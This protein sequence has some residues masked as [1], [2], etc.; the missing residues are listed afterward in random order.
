MKFEELANAWYIEKLPYVRVATEKNYKGIKNTLVKHFGEMETADISVERIQDF[1]NMAREKNTKET[2]VSRKKI[3][4]QIFSY[5]E[6]IG[7]VEHNPVSEIKIPKCK[8]SKEI[9]IVTLGELEKLMALNI[10]QY[11]KDMIQIGFRT[12]MRI[13]EIL[14]LRWEDINFEEGYLIVNR[15]LSVY[16]GGKPYINAPKTQTSYRAIDLDS[17]LMAVLR[18]RHEEQSPKS[19]FVFVKKNGKIYSRQ[20]VG[21]RNLCRQAGIPPRGFHSLR[22][23][24]VSYILSHKINPDVAQKRAGHANPDITL[25]IYNHVLP[26]MQ[27]EVTKLMEDIPYN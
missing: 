5:A 4:N 23:T 2:L 3:L 25:R 22:H 6:E 13:G 21:F 1:I 27:R 19:G 24:H 8:N 15:T 7:E 12:G 9:K 11:K 26:D 17:A 14:T 10:S 20:A 18:M 16:N